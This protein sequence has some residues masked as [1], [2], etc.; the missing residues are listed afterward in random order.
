METFRIQKLKNCLRQF[1]FE[2]LLKNY[3]WEG[4]KIKILEIPIHL[5]KFQFW[6]IEE[7]PAA[8]LELKS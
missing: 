3:F 5:W 8:I 4:D 6:K 1:Q 2:N 7:L